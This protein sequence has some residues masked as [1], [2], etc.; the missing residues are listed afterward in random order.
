MTTRLSTTRLALAGTN[1]SLR[2]DPCRP[3]VDG[4]RTTGRLRTR[5]S[6]IRRAASL[7]SFHSES[8]R[9]ALL[10]S[11][12]GNSADRVTIEYHQP[13]VE[14]QLATRGRSL[15][16]GNFQSELFVEGTAVATKG[17]WRAVCWSSDDD[18]D[19]LELQLC[20][21]DSVHID[22][23]FLLSRRG[24]F[25]LFADAVV[26]AAPARIE[27]RLSL[28][29]A[30]GIFV[31]T[32]EPT[33][34]CRVGTARVFPL[35]LPQDRVLSTPGNCST[36]AGRL[37][38]TQVAAGRGLYLPIVFDWHPRRRRAPADWRSLTVTEPGRVVSP[39]GAAGHRLR[40]GKEQLLIYRSL[41][42][43]REARA[44]LGQHT[45]YETVIGSIDSGEMA[46]I[47]M[48]ETDSPC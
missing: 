14:F 38:L 28:P 15:L 25:A 18:G 4:S 22:R 21:S 32:D 8:T 23:Q 1:G 40:V 3:Q 19:Y 26:T 48:V 17:D 36:K 30:G 12:T 42:G 35:G 6:A 46:P 16:A 11:G 47:V 20:V 37:D 34:E 10:Q 13:G 5:S 7:R 29:V 43:T 31:K 45:R 24:H 41:V 9:E 39:D 27:Y 33:R 2:P 44:V